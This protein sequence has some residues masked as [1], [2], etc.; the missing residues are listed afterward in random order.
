MNKK[1][2]FGSIFAVFLLIMIPTVSALEYNT[3]L[4]GKKSLFIQN[5]ENKGIEIEEIENNIHKMNIIEFR[6]SILNI[7]IDELNGNII[8]NIEGSRLSKSEKTYLKEAIASINLSKILIR[9]IMIPTL[10][11]FI[12]N[13]AISELSIF[14]GL[15]IIIIIGLAVPTFFINPIAEELEAET[16]ISSTVISLSLSL[17]CIILAAILSITIYST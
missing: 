1:I 12:G 13:I 9:G 17:I 16:G 2:L 8:N 11:Y 6:K 7:D 15:I 4:N 10:L 3:S 14:L 5:L